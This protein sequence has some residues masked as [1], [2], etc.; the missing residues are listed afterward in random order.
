MLT[1]FFTQSVLKDIKDKKFN[2]GNIISLN[3]HIGGLDKEYSISGATEEKILQEL[4]RIQLEL[5]TGKVILSEG[6]GTR[7]SEKTQGFIIEEILEAKLVEINKYAIDAFIK[8]N[9]F[10]ISEYQN[11]V[12]A[13]VEDCISNVMA[14]VNK[15]SLNRNMELN[16]LYFGAPSRF[17]YKGEALEYYLLNTNANIDYVS[18]RNEL[19]IIKERN[20]IYDGNRE[21]PDFAVFMNGLPFVCIEA[22]SEFVNGVNGIDEAF[23]DYRNKKSYSSFLCCIGMD[24]ISA[25]ISSTTHKMYYWA[26]YGYS[27]AYKTSGCYVLI[28]DLF[29]DMDRFLFYFECCVLRD[30]KSNTLKNARV[31]QFRAGYTLFESIIKR[32]TTHN[33]LFFQHHTRT[34][35]SFTFKIIVEMMRRKQSFYKKIILFVPDTSS[36]YDGL[37]DEFKGMSFDNGLIQ[38]IKSRKDYAIALEKS[39]NDHSLFS[40]YMMNMQKINKDTEIL[41]SGSD[42]L[43]LIDEVHT[44]QKTTELDFI[45]EQRTLADLR[46]LHFPNASIISATATPLFKGK[47]KNI[48]EE[49]YG[50]CIDKLSPSDAVRLKIV[51][52]LE[53]KQ[54]SYIGN[55]TM[56]CINFIKDHN[57]DDARQIVESVVCTLNDNLYEVINDFTR[58]ERINLIDG[59]VDVILNINFTIENI[60][61][62]INLNPFQEGSIYNEEYK[63]MYLFLT[64]VEKVAYKTIQKNLSEASAIVSKFFWSNFAEKKIRDIVVPQIKARRREC[65]RHYMPKFFYIVPARDKGMGHDISYGEILINIIKSMIRSYIIQNDDYD[66]NKW[67]EHN[68]IYDG[69]RFGFDGNDTE[70]D[71]NGEMNDVETI[72]LFEKDDK[73]ELSNNRPIDGGFKPID[74]LIVVRKRTKGYTN[75]NLIDIF[76]DRKINNPH[77]MLQLTTRGTTMRTH[78]DVSSVIDMTIGNSNK[79]VFDEAMRLYDHDDKELF[80]LNNNHIQDKCNEIKDIIKDVLHLINH[81][82]ILNEILSVENFNNNYYMSYLKNNIKIIYKEYLNNNY[83]SNFIKRFLELCYRVQ[84][85][86]LDSIGVK[87]VIL[88]GNDIVLKKNLYVILDI[89]HLLKSEYA[90]YNFSSSL[91]SGKHT[92]HIERA[93]ENSNIIDFIESIS[94][95]I[96]GNTEDAL[97]DDNEDPYSYE[98]RLRKRMYSIP[99]I[100]ISPIE[101]KVEEVIKNLD[102]LNNNHINELEQKF[103]DII[104][105]QYD[106]NRNWAFIS[107][108][109]KPLFEEK[110]YWLARIQGKKILERIESKKDIIKTKDI[111]ID[112]YRKHIFD[113]MDF[114]K[115]PDSLT[116]QQK[117]I[118]RDEGLAKKYFYTNGILTQVQNL[119]D[120]NKK[121][122]N[123]I[124]DILYFITKD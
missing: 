4:I 119:F 103:Q 55:N 9:N 10:D 72:K 87:S 84:K 85:I 65:D 38:E 39:E 56:D 61:N 6:L 112:I 25:F 52:P 32:R 124:E 19:T 75:E 67:D 46:T 108:T 77:D 3:Y 26:D 70:D 50:K 7:I 66:R 98:E 71:I 117:N 33:K 47:H 80:I 92:T 30:D 1:N 57:N 28:N 109:I 20:L 36:T 96:G 44:H 105:T 121:E 53:Y 104:E 102:T 123:A 22:K 79:E 63:Q 41:D 74:V 82:H 62:I 15:K 114:K 100:I 106:N 115:F 29:S 99:S 2:N 54:I 83:Q 13:L 16:D 81:E 35:K 37:H 14:I 23:K 17:K 78:K 59:V 40:V 107:E 97:S 24:G 12:D 31:Q 8:D 89:Y 95:Q 60:E 69:I 120:I 27:N 43:L 64:Y 18:V 118:I 91:V 122:K 90:L 116:E 58:K 21:I 94:F 34:G 86:I 48:T 68:I 111:D 113:N 110:D 42:V 88:Q 49:L 76:I 101:S 5:A 11:I 73:K 45:Q 93:L 51:C